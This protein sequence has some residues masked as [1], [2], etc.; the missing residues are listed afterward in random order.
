[1]SPVI[2]VS[3]MSPTTIVL[4]PVLLISKSLAAVLNTQALTQLLLE[5]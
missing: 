3:V 5:T 4:A 2:A 1:M